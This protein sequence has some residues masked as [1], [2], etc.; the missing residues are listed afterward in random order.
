M[1]TLLASLACVVA[2]AAALRST[3]SPC[4]WSMLST[5]TPLAEQS[6][7][8]RYSSTATWFIVGSLVGGI[9]LGL[10]AALLAAFVSVIGITNSAALGLA[11]VAAV[12]TATS[13]LGVAGM[14]LP[15]TVR[16]VNEVWLGRY[17]SWVYGAGFG[18]QVG[19]GLA[20]FLMTA[21]VYLVV[22]LAALTASPL[23]AL[24]ICALFGLMRGFAILLGASITS[25]ERLV[26][27]HRR[28]DAA[29]EP[30]RR[31]VIAVQYLA[32]AVFAAVAWS[33][34]VPIVGGVLIAGLAATV[35][36]TRRS[37]E[38]AAS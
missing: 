3:W 26:V 13:D 31:V 20:T 35:T 33:V 25:P 19:V 12:V 14:K 2:V 24:S 16:Q 8:H 23:V 17:R 11:A 5:I 9:T 15:G 7:G 38:P 10:G 34:V 1:T 21:A 36:A 29:A 22:V 30:V 37:P 4:G 6:R 28:F 18:W 32:A 27:F